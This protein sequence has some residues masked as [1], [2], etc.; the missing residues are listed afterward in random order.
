LLSFEDPKTPPL[1]SFKPSKDPSILRALHGFCLFLGTC[2][3][4]FLLTFLDVPG[5][6]D[7][8]LGKWVISPTYYPEGEL[9]VWRA[10]QGAEYFP[11][12]QSPRSISW[13]SWVISGVTFPISGFCGFFAL[14]R[15]PGDF[16]MIEYSSLRPHKG[17]L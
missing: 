14:F 5:S 13:G 2:E 8:W 12:K 6:V 11:K 9:L 1:H 3:D 7:Q 10:N 15:M 17:P 4:I 16:E